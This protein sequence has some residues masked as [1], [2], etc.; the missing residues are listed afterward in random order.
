MPHSSVEG[1]FAMDGFKARL[2]E[3][4][5][6]HLGITQNTFEDSCGIT[7]GTVSSIKVKGP[8]VDVLAKISYTYP[9]LN[10]NWLISGRGEM[11]IK[12]GTP[13]PPSSPAVSIGTIKT[14]NIGNWE[15]LVKLLKDKMK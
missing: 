3:F 11:L 13:P 1:T 7:H 12:E 10:M 8:S 2:V 5:S 4:F 15:E 9:E 14:V 6:T